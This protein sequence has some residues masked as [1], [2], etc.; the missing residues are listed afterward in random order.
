MSFRVKAL[1]LEAGANFVRE[2]KS[3][4]AMGSRGFNALQRGGGRL[5]RENVSIKLGA[6]GAKPES[7]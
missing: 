1:V 4:W 2:L 7:H 5:H 6:I 3:A